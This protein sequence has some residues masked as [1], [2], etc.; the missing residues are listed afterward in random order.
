MHANTGS[1]SHRIGKMIVTFILIDLAW[2]FFRAESI[3]VAADYISRIFR[4]FDPWALFDGS[5]LKLGLDQVE[6]NV[7]SLAMAV[8]IVVDLVQYV[9]GIRIDRMLEG[10]RLWFRWGV[11]ILL[12]T[13]VWV[14]GMYGPAFSSSNFI[15][16]SF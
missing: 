8:L 5:L 6:A 14:F 10:Q 3:G 16:Q 13:C 12:I 11:I 4:S 9:R 2:I 15:Y 7:L 1:V